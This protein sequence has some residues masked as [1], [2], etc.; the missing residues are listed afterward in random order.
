MYELPCPHCKAR[1]SLKLERDKDEKRLVAEVIAPP[2][3]VEDD[4]DLSVIDELLKDGD[5]HKEDSPAGG[6]EKAGSEDN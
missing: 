3:E 5:E 6:K 2:E 1:L 4:D